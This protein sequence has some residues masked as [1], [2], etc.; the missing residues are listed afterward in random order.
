MQTFLNIIFAITAVIGVLGFVEVQILT[1]SYTK[2]TEK[3]KDSL[4]GLW[5]IINKANKLDN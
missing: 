4:E 2:F 5:R 1:N 3:V